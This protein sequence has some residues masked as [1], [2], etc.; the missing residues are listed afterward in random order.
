[1]KA[2]SIE[3]IRRHLLERAHSFAKKV[4][5]VYQVLGWEW[6]GVG[7]PTASDI[8]S[9]IEDLIGELCAGIHEAS[10]GGIT[11][12]IDRGNREYGIRMDITSARY[13]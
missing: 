7:T 13:Y 5:P 3:V 9:T 1:M 10:T 4:A 12:Y 8:E 2:M 6:S 11:V